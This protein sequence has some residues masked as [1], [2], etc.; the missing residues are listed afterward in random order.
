MWRRDVA[1]LASLN[2][3]VEAVRGPL[4]P[5]WSE[6]HEHRMVLEIGRLVGRELSGPQ[7]PPESVAFERVAALL[8][9]LGAGSA[10]AMPWDLG[11]TRVVVEDAHAPPSSLG[12]WSWCLFVS[13][14]LAGA[15]GPHAPRQVVVDHDRCRSLGDERCEYVVAS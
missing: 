3:L 11:V 5:V 15:V 7:A 14:L 1:L 9:R 8:R 2:D 6:R 4:P 13:G 10:R 12:D